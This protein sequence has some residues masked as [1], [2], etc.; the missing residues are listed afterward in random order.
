MVG[1]PLRLMIYDRTCAGRGP[2]PGLTT[3]WR[4]GGLLYRGLGRLDRSAGFSDWP[5]ALSWLAATEPDRPIGEIQFWGH[6]KWGRALIDGASLDASALAPGAPL[7]RPLEAVRERLSGPEAL[8]WF[9]TCETFG[10]RRGHDF[11]RRLT[12]FLG[13]RAASHTFI[14]AVWQSGLHSLAP[15]EEPGWP[16]DEGL[17]E[18]TPEAP[19]KAHW[20]GRREPNTITCFHNRVP[21]G[22]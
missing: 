15:G 5:S 12:D 6:G 9:R 8:V 3:S 17:A 21:A 20:S 4:A 2:L 19:E 1:A 22:Y 10:A 16:A 14:I 13:C 11:A 18:G 7:R